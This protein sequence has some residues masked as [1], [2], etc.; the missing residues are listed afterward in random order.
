MKRYTMKDN[1]ASAAVA[2]LIAVV[3]FIVLHPLAEKERADR[4]QQE[5]E[6]V[7]EQIAADRAYEAEVAAERARWDA[8]ENNYRV[9]AGVSSIL[10]DFDSDVVIDTEFTEPHGFSMIQSKDWDADDAYLLAKIAMAEAEG[11]GTETKALVICVVLNRVWSDEFPGTISEVIFED[12]Q[13]SPVSNG[14]WDRVE[15]NEDC[16]KALAMVEDGWDESQGATYFELTRDYTTWHSST[17]EKLFESGKTSFY[18]S[19]GDK[20]DTDHAN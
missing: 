15:P 9:T 20:E 6:W 16:W 11:E 10:Y 14:R 18:K 13:F 3:L 1:L 12:N 8:M 4:R 5:R 2:V 17:L 19:H 7:R